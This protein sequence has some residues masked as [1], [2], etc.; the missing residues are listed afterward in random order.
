MGWERSP[1]DWRN[2]L[3]PVA[4]FSSQMAGV[5]LEGVPPIFST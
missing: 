1:E 2:G 5:W 4:D 3:G